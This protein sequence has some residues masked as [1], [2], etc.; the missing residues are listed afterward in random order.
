MTSALLL[1][2]CL[3]LVALN[4]FFVLAEFAIVKVRG[5][6]IEELAEGG[7]VAALWVRS[8]LQRLDG[9]LSAT[10]LGITI[11]SLALGWIGEPAIAHLVE[12]LLS[13]AG[14]MTPVLAHTVAVG[15]AFLAI[16]FL[17]VVFG[18]LAPK[19]LAIRRPEA[20]ALLVALPLR[21]FYYLFYP[22][23]WI[24]E[25][26]TNVALRLVGISPAAE[27]K[28]HSEEELRMIL[29]RSHE[30]GRLGGL[31]P[32]LLENLL[33]FSRLTSRQIM[34]PRTDVVF[35]SLDAPPETTLAVA[36]ESGHTRFPVCRGG[37]DQVVGIAHIKSIFNRDPGGGP[38]DL[39]AIMREALF[40]PETMPADRLLRTFQRRR[41]HMA[42]VVDEYGGASGIVTI[43]DAIEEIVG[44][45]QD[46]FDEEPPEIAAGTDGALAIDGLARLGDVVDRL[47]APDGDLPDV[48]TIGG[49]V[50]ARLG[51]LARSGDVAPLGSWDLRV[52]DARGGRVRRIEARRRP[53]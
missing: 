38:L 30:Q 39:T 3:L 33:G 4:A 14:V 49:Y 27:E 46:E 47:G 1:T 19:S 16:T 40:V 23:I 44:D 35:L 6:R 26:A 13:G 5:T 53:A 28:A 51:R 41:L 42:I 7:S 20:S 2:C 11:A 43:E 52:L 22:L 12:P 25:S 24:F 8:V 50:Q 29:A 48:D 36:R 31:R 45:V 18:E 9:H 10:Q 34:V 15:T 21:A 17:H 32:D 37:L